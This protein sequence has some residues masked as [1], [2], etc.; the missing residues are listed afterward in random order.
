MV[1]TKLL[2]VRTEAAMNGITTNLTT[3]EATIERGLKT[4]VE[5]GQAL[6]AIRDGKLY[7]EQYDR[8]EDYCKERWGWNRDRAYKLI[9]AADAA[10]NVSQGIHAA[11]ESERVARPLAKLPADEQ[12]DAWEEVVTDAEEA[13][14]KITAKR[15]QQVVAKRAKKTKPD[16]SVALAEAEM[17]QSNTLTMILDLNDPKASAGWIAKQCDRKYFRELVGYLNGHLTTG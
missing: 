16:P 14:E 10:G 9:A 4:F 3:H 13:G 6:Q 11:P 12:A 17:L 2:P 1:D 8:F 5:V 7:R 15:V